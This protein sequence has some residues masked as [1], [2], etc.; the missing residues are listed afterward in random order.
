MLEQAGKREMAG[1]AGVQDR[2][3]QTGGKRLAG[4]KGET[5]RSDRQADRQEGQAI[6]TVLGSIQ[7]FSYTVESERRKKKH[8]RIYYVKIQAKWL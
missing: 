3:E 6:A 4:Q 2:Q 1:R 7:A 5:S 8:Y